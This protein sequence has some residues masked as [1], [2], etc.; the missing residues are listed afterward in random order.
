MAENDRNRLHIHAVSDQ[1]FVADMLYGILASVQELKKSYDTRR[2]VCGAG[3]NP[4]DDHDV[5][6]N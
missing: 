3:T 6:P 1:K 4:G 5:I 2:Q